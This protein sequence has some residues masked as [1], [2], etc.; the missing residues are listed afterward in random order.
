MYV[1]GTAPAEGD[2]AGEITAS[3]SPFPDLRDIW[4]VHGYS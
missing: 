2:G 1:F 4:D 3:L